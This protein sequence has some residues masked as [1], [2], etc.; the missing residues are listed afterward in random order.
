MSEYFHVVVRLKA[1]TSPLFL[2]GDLSK[3]ELLGCF[4]RPYQL[5]R[6]IMNGNDRVDLME[7]ASVQIICTRQDKETSLQS[8]RE[9]SSKRIDDFNADA[10]RTGVVIMTMGAGWQDEDIVCAGEDVTSQYIKEGPGA[11]T[12]LTNLTKNQ[13]IITVVGGLIVVLVGALILA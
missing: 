7:V 2:F 1:E 11:G 6:S 9:D 12:H 13:W 3:K 5:G 8:V 4:V 10:H